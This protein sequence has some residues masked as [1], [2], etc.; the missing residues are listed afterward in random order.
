[1]KL[2][3]T[4]LAFG[5]FCALQSEAAG[6]LCRFCVDFVT[7]FENELQ[8]GEGTIEQK[9]NKACDNVTK[10]NSFLDPI[11]KMLIDKEVEKIVKSIEQNDPPQKVCAGL[12]HLC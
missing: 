4:L 11:C 9:A 6:P 12:F 3:L 8:N 10:G 7:A 2:L 5:T 1:M